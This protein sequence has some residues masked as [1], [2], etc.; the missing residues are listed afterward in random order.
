MNMRALLI[1]F[2]LIGFLKIS[3]IGCNNPI[4]SRSQQ[5][6]TVGL[7]SFCNYFVKAITTKDTLLFYQSVDSDKLLTYI[8]TKHPEAAI[9]KQYLFFP[10]F[11]VF[12]PLKIMTDSLMVLRES[13]SFNDFKVDTT[14]TRIEGT[15]EA[16]VRWQ[17]TGSRDNQ[18]IQ[19]VLIKEDNNWKVIG[20]DWH[21][22]GQ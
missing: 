19:L 14:N 10:F 1:N 20:A 3:I 5:L 2:I 6:D 21:M 11:F 8:N 22:I 18:Q 12:S 15:I 16:E 9:K 7:Y 13:R 4:T 17:V